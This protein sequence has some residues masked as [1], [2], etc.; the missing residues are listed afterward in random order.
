MSV[1]ASYIALI[2]KDAGSDYGVSFPDLPGC[3][4]AGS[5]LDEAR[6]MA[7]EA[8]ALHIEGL[9]EFGDAVPEPSTLQDIMADQ[10]NHDGVAILVDPPADSSR[11]VRVTI[12]L[13]EDILAEIDRFAQGSGLS[14]SAFL[15]RTAQEEMRRR[16][17]R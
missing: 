6:V 11:A 9:Q 3:V 12:T 5:T 4:S 16:E 15:A 7:A 2:H 17:P 13:P 1:L 8:L 10:E 14:R